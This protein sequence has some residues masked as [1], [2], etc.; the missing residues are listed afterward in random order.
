MHPDP[1][2]RHADGSAPDRRVMLAGLS[3]FQSPSTRRSVTQLGITAAPYAVL[4]AF[5]YYAYYHISPWLSLA[6]ALPAA[7]LVVRL[8]IIQHDCG[9]GAYFRSRWA[10]EAVG[11]L[12]SLTTY[13]PYALWR[14]H[15]AA[16]QRREGKRA[17][18]HKRLR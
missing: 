10:N 5:M 11:L 16:H 2:P 4:V 8:F 12:C 15:H 9:H 14:R 18:L 1:L 17:A 7:G 13:T 6:L 3:A